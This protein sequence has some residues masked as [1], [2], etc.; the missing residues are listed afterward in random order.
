MTERPDIRITV[1]HRHP[2]HGH[3]TANVTADGTTRPVDCRWGSWQTEDKEGNRYDVLPKI[4][5]ALQARVRPIE[6][7]ERVEVGHA[8]EREKHR[9]LHEFKQLQPSKRD[10]AR[11]LEELP[12]E[13][14]DLLVGQPLER[15]YTTP[16]LAWARPAG[17]TVGA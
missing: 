15:I 14:A 2:E 3:W 7:G 10:L 12:G 16:A 4:A 17:W 1:L 11:F 8:V 6:R 9:R 5:E 13:L